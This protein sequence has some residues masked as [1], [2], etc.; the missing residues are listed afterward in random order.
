MK[1]YWKLFGVLVFALLVYMTYPFLE[2]I[3][4]A[5]FLY[6]LAKPIKK[7]LDKKIESKEITS[8][9]AIITL[10]S[11]IVI[12]TMVSTIYIA[13]TVSKS[14]PFLI[15]L[16]ENI[17]PQEYS[18]HINELVSSIKI[19]DVNYF[20]ELVR[21]RDIQSIVLEP[22]K[23]LTEVFLW[24]LLIM[25]IAF[26][27][28]FYFL[29]DGESLMGWAV[30]NAPQRDE[31]IIDEYIG[32]M[33]CALN[34]IFVGVFL[35]MVITLIFALISLTVL[36]MVAPAE[37]KISAALILGLSVLCGLFNLLPGVGIKI[38]WVPTAIL[39][40][41]QAYFMGTLMA[42][43]WYLLIFALVMAVIVDFVPDQ[44]LRPYICGAG[45]H[46]GLVLLSFVFG[47]VVFG[48]KGLFLGPIILVGFIEYMKTVVPQLS[49]E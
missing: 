1:G 28:G 46:T 42:S 34:R 35:T 4:Y 24:Y 32:N 39:F 38:V 18:E 44:I 14:F 22:L 16:I 12:P 8:F 47:T 43:L 19:L 5:I 27:V 13:D 17:L 37:L 21:S 11:L 41:L 20:L 29:M 48:A 9:I 26:V 25:F 49:D 33:D 31:K 23:R 10:L 40:T 2:G 7:Q 6:Y 36:N 30:D 15:E 45:I 3:V